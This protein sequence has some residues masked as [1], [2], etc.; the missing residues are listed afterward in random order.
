VFN[1]FFGSE[2][3]DSGEFVRQG[4]GNSQAFHTASS[5][6]P[7]FLESTFSQLSIFYLLISR[8]LKNL[9]HMRNMRWAMQILRGRIMFEGAS[10]AFYRGVPMADSMVYFN[11]FDAEFITN[12]KL[13]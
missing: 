7:S 5:F 9:A 12:C 13:R 1:L 11:Y 10:P 2:S 4:C 6:R 8:I 3:L